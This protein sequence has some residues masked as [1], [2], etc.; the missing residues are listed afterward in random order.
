MGRAERAQ[1]DN[2]LAPGAWHKKYMLNAAGLKQSLLGN[3]RSST[4]TPKT[5]STTAKQTQE[6]KDE[7][8]RQTRVPGTTGIREH[9]PR[10]SPFFPKIPISKK[11]QPP[12]ERR[13]QHCGRSRSRS[14]I[15]SY[16]VAGAKRGKGNPTRTRPSQSP[17]QKGIDNTLQ[18]AATAESRA[19]KGKRGASRP[20]SFTRS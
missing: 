10:P 4:H 2:A 1:K 14:S 20:R 17:S 16:Y 5:T 9:G 8:R 18:M 19:R 3:A 13:P 6:W 11:R 15:A 12:C 7:S